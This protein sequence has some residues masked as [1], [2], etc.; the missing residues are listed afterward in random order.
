MSG[1]VPSHRAGLRIC[2]ECQA[3]T[4]ELVHPG[5]HAPHWVGGVLVNCAGKRLG[6]ES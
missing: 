5:Q 3:V 4:S 6:G 1:L 2:G